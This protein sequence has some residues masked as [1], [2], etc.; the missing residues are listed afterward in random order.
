MSDLESLHKVGA[1]VNVAEEVWCLF[2]CGGN[3][4][5]GQSVAA[6]VVLWEK[7]SVFNGC[8]VESFVVWVKP[9]P[10]ASKGTREQ[11]SS[12]VK[13]FNGG[14][15]IGRR[16]VEDLEVAVAFAQKED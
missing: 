10:D 1:A 12:N 3:L 11:E 13:A 5:M 14:E 8:V 9:S 4:A 6:A 16:G 7:D 2:F 15:G